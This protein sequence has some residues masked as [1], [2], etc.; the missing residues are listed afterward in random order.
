[1]TLPPPGVDNGSTGLVP[2]TGFTVPRPPAPGAEKR[3]IRMR[4]QPI[5]G[6]IALFFLACGYY[7][8]S[9]WWHSPNSLTPIPNGTD[10]TFFEWMFVHGVRVF[11][12]GENPL[13]TSQLNAPVG[14]NLMSN[15]SL[16]GLALPFAPLTAWLGPAPVFV[17]A[18][19]LGL[20]GTAFA[21]Y[22]V[23]SRHI[24]HNRIG[25]F[26]GG[27]VCG[28]GPGIV[29]HANAHPNLTAQFVLPF[30]VWRALAIRHSNRLVR[31][32]VI[33]G[34]LITYQVFLNEE[35]LFLTAFAGLLF[36]LSYAVFRRPEARRAVQ[37]MALGFGVALAVAAPLL[38]YPMWFQFYGP[39]HFSGLPDFLRQYPYRLPLDSFV[40]YPSLSYFGTPLAYP[41]GTEQNSFFGWVVIIAI[42]LIVVTL[43]RRRPAVRALAIV[44]VFFAWASLGDQ[45]VYADPSTPHALSLWDHLSHL[46]LFDS[47]LPSRLAMVCVPVVGILFAYAVTDMTSVFRTSYREGESLRIAGSMLGLAGMAVALFTIFPSPVTMAPVGTVPTFFSS[48][49]WR[50][51]VPGGDSVLSATPYDTISFMRWDIAA[52]LDFPVPGG[53]FLGPAPLNPGQKTPVGQFGPQW[54]N[55][56]LVMGSI[57][58][59]SWQLPDDATPYQ[60]GVRADLKYWHTAIIVLTSDQPYGTDEKLAIDKL[61]GFSGHQVGDVWLWDVRSISG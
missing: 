57:G 56:M 48:G 34:L 52:G 49:Q 37:P 9:A 50:A 17:L 25:A 29:T 7:V 8:T 10:Q 51:Y 40:T 35:L 27:L 43:W 16:L 26:V 39:Q 20:S 1:V 15:T 18:I 4:I 6:L 58:A 28:F 13:F 19:M 61:L 41:S 14:V 23:L 3:P 30:I 32:G 11:T 54:R 22:W 21:W 60:A 46:P 53:Y 5:D 47:V 59:N 38:A 42:A 45:V 55:T 24:V 36:G 12:H 2:T 31:D 44:G 33:L